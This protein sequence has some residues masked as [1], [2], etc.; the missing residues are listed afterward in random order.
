MLKVYISIKYVTTTRSI[1][2][3]STNL[4]FVIPIG[5]TKNKFVLCVSILLVVVTYFMT[6]YLLIYNTWLLT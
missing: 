2:T 4:F 3:H 6:V 5:I 1:D